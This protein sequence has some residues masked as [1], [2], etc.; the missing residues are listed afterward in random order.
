[1]NKPIPLFIVILLCLTAYSLY[2]AQD[3]MHRGE[4]GLCFIMLIIA[5]IFWKKIQKPT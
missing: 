5:L 3:A 1:M 2:A 4:R